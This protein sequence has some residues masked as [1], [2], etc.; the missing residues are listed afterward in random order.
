MMRKVSWA[1]AGL[2]LMAAV[3]PAQPAS[4]GSVVTVQRAVPFGW[5]W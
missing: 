1:I 4:P 5:F 3:A 2:L